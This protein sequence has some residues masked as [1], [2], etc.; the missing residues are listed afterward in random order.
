LFHVLLVVVAGL[1]RLHS[2]NTLPL[3]PINTLFL[4][5]L[6]RCVSKLLVAVVVAVVVPDKVRLL[7]PEL[8]VVL[9]A[10]LSLEPFRYPLWR[11]RHLRL[12]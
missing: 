5:E 12:P 11:A 8:R 4:R 10:D 2:L 9:A 3:V 7:Y 6:R 1:L